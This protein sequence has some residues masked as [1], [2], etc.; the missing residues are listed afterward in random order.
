MKLFSNKDDKLSSLTSKP[1]KLEREIQN[2]VEKN[3]DELF[4]LQFVRTEFSIKNFRFDTLCFDKESKSF[5][6]IEYKLGRNFS[7]I[8]QGYT[9]M[10]ILINNPSDFI[11]EYNERLGV[12]LKRGDVDW[13]QSRVIFI[14]TDYTEYQKHSVNFKDVPFELWEVKQYENNMFGMVQ[15]KNN[16]EESITKISNNPNNVISKVSKKVKIFDEKFHLFT[17]SRPD[18]VIELYKKIKER[19]LNL[20]DVEIKFTGQ[21]ISFRKKSPFVDIVIYNKGLYTIINMK[22]GTLNDPN[23]MT[24]GFEGKGHWGNGDYFVLINQKT[25]LD[26]VMFLINQSFQN[27][28]TD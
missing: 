13:S 18:W 3:L 10:S 1:F 7:V 6:V 12:T 17:K 24:K 25:D 22:E 21:Y 9:Y 8:D 19:I 23:K 11:L 16:S 26:Y 28:K 5:V 15:H 4:N 27:K 14:S 20:G 2:L